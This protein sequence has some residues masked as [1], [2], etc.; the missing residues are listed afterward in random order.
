MEE[1]D[2]SYSWDGADCWGQR[3]AVIEVLAL[4]VSGQATGTFL[5]PQTGSS[6]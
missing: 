1:G 5:C 2:K 3:D 4:R 6:H